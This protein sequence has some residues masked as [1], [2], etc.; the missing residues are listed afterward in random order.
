MEQ[1][2]L[3]AGQID[4]LVTAEGNFGWCGLSEFSHE[5]YAKRWLLSPA[6]TLEH[7][8]GIP[9]NSEEYI[10]YEP[11]YSPK[12]LEDIS[13]DSCTLHYQPAACSQI[14]CAI[15]YRLVPPH[16]VDVNMQMTTS[17]THWPLNHVALFFATIVNAPL[18]TGINLL[19]SDI[20]VEVKGDN[21][22]V[23]FN[24]LAARKGRTAHPAGIENPELPRPATPPDTY[25]YNDSSVRFT[26]PFFYG[27]VD[28]M[29][30][31]TMFRPETKGHTLRCQSAC[32]RLRWPGLG[33]P[34]DNSD[35]PSQK[36]IRAIVSK[37]VEALY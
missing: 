6:F 23:H 25:Y 20:E 1:A 24:G 11:C 31:A 29:V 17:R 30:F 12:R 19:G 8:I 33:F 26:Q 4:V 2:R 35:A 36:S 28:H 10:D 5:G 21:P 3:F 27:T 34:L 14:D 32:T 16:Y 18:Y 22:W 9:M 13:T 7:Y 15:T 37:P